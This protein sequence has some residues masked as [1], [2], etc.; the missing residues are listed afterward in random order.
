MVLV[1][2]LYVSRSFIDFPRDEWK[3]VDIVRVAR[4]RNRLLSVTGAL[5]FTETH[6]A[7]VLEGPATAV[8]ELMASIRRDDRHSDVTVIETEAMSRRRF[9]NWSMAYWGPA[10]L[11]EGQLEPVLAVAAGRGSVFASRDLIALMMQ[12]AENGE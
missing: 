9:G 12:L 1:S 4:E 8:D 5:M 3:V 2:L 10:G 7:Q 11:V 6:F